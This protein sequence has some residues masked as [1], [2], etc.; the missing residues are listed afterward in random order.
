M[1][2]IATLPFPEGW[3]RHMH[4]LWGTPAILW[5][6]GGG[7]AN[8]YLSVHQKSDMTRTRRAY[9]S[10]KILSLC[11]RYAIWQ[12]EQTIS[13][14]LWFKLEWQ[15]K[16]PEFPEYLR[17]LSCWSKRIHT[18][19]SLYL[20]QKIGYLWVVNNLPLVWWEFVHYMTISRA[21]HCRKEFSGG[22]F[23]SYT[24]KDGLFACYRVCQGNVHI[25]FIYVETKRDP[26]IAPCR[27][28]WYRFPD[29]PSKHH[30]SLLISSQIIKI[31]FQNEL[32]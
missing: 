25:P 2:S 5:K 30:V 14:K 8:R 27:H 4:D 11:K 17:F 15:F 19:R 6:E 13:W 26:R 31:Y 24:C 9:N 18:L 1:Y 20:K 23:R 28:V 16:I 32:K 21:R 7:G 12:S 3:L 10:G 22:A 29:G